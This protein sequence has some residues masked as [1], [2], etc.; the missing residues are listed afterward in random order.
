MSRDESLAGH[1]ARAADRRPDGTAV[2]D[3]DATV[4]AGDLARRAGGIAAALRAVGV[5]PGQRVGLVL[6]K[7]VDAVAA[8]HGVL[9][10]G[11]AY[12]PIDPTAPAP[13][14]RLI[15]ADAEVAALVSHRPRLDLARSI[16]SGLDPAPR[17]VAVD[18]GADPDVVPAVPTDLHPMRRDGDD[19]AY[20]LYTSGSTGVPKGVVL[21]HG[22]G[23]AFVTWA[24]ELLG[25]TAEDR[26]SS[27]APF[28]FDLS[29]FD[30]FASVRAGATLVLVP[31]RLA[32]FPTRLAAFA[33][34]QALTIWYSVPSVLTMLVE[35]G[36]LEAGAL[37]TLRHVVFAGEVFPLPQL[38]RLMGLVDGARY[39][40]FYGPTETNVCTAYEVATVPSP[41]VDAIPI[42]AVVTP[43]VGWVVD[44]DDRPLGTGE[45]GELVVGG[46]TVAA[47]Y[48][49][50]PQLTAE[51]FVRLVGP[52]GEA[53]RVYRTGD[54]VVADDDGQLWFRG[55]RDHQVKTAGHR[56]ELGEVE[57]V[58]SA[59]DGV[60]DGVVVALPD[61][62][63]GRRLEA[64]VVVRPGTD[65]ANV[66]RR[67]EARLPSYM[68]PRV[69]HLVAELPRT[70]TGKVDRQA[71]EEH[72]AGV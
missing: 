68:V 27:H 49:G 24:S 44:D 1:L 36:G 5:A 6:D 51:R 34:E 43:D 42:G 70:S 20:I 37:P 40:N 3:G 18:G 9:A 29:V 65:G 39:W 2:I 30:L 58:L 10:A 22:N 45:E 72:L 16:A 48:A 4:S 33:A 41:E 60:V 57:A 21:T 13:R 56:V 52:D 64:V 54:L 23:G 59:V 66:K 35:R 12:V 69:V 55:R 15:A 14:S 25:V 7:S 53:H 61:P 28:H 17:L 47:G 8:V 11:A 38:R 67:C 62:L 46:A 31:R 32:M 71:V 26:L 63:V 50:A 19:A